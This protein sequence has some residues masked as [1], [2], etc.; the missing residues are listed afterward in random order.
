MR[1]KIAA[2]IAFNAY[3]VCVVSAFFHA[4]PEL[5][6][7]DFRSARLLPDLHLK[8]FQWD[9]RSLL[10]LLLSAAAT[11]ISAALAGAI[12]KNRGGVVAAKSALPLTLLWIEIFFVS[13]FTGTFGA[14]VLSLTAIPLTILISSYSGNLGERM[15][16]DHFPET[17]VFGIYPYH[18][19]WMIVPFFL[20]AFVLATW[21][22]YFESA[23]FRDWLEARL[24]SRIAGILS[25]FYVLLPASGLA[26]L[27]YLV[28]NILTGRIFKIES[29]WGRAALTI[30][31]LVI[32]PI[33]LY[34]VL[35]WIGWLMKWIPVEGI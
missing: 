7:L 33:L 5:F 34:Q 11:S 16:R 3:W 9:H 1:R 6:R 20:S 23:L 17:T 12:A 32:V 28:Y 22:P 8:D 24:S 27:L 21:L 35:V 31:L 26:G 29:E 19:I 18:L 10:F 2:F 14:T 4:L 13:L 30:G 15:Q 25:L